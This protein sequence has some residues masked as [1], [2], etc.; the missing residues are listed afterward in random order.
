MQDSAHLMIVDEDLIFN[1]TP[2]LDPRFRPKEV[3]LLVAPLLSEEA[4]RLTRLLQ[5]TGIKVTRW[6]VSDPWDI[7]HVRE[8]VHAFIQQRQGDEIM[9]NASGGTKLMGLGAY[10]AFRSADRPVYYVHPESDHV[11]WLHPQSRPSFNLADRIKLPAFLA[12]QDLRLVQVVRQGVSERLRNLTTYLASHTP[13][14]EGPL[15]VLNWYASV[16]KGLTSPPVKTQH[17]RQEG[18][19]RLLELF[20]SQGLLEV[21]PKQRLVFPDEDA[22]FYVNGGWLEEHV[23]GVLSQLRREI[24][25]IQDLGRSLIVEWDEQ[26]SPVTNE[27]DVA[28]LANNRFYLVE[29]KTKRFDDSKSADSQ[30]SGTLYKLDTLRSHLGG[31][32]A[33]AVLVS[34]REIGEH[35][36][37]RASEMGIPICDGGQLSRLD[38]VLR[39]MIE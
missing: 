30:L 28:F 5:P 10:E 16:T 20:A 7:A 31:V 8:R 39:N 33:R 32:D 34:Y 25:T 13:Q 4:Q 29:C 18:I 19:A 3:C 38:S 17:I 6:E 21:D 9:L 2:A 22:R 35:A 14:F 11:V 1:I 12:A 37:L 15:A 27:I 36:R 26:S 23:F 24:P